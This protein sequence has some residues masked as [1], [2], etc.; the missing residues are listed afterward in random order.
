M[1]EDY[2]TKIGGSNMKKIMSQLIMITMVLALAACVNAGDEDVAETSQTEET[3][4]EERQDDSESEDESDLAYV[5][6]NGKLIIGYTVLEPMNF[7]DEDGTFTGFD[8]ELAIIVANRLGLEPEFVEIN[9][10]T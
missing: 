3:K 5:K 6:D 7:S 10:D 1:L 8:T 9:W 2:L 4:A